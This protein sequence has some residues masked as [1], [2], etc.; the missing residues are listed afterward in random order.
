MTRKD[1]MKRTTRVIVYFLDLQPLNLKEIFGPGI[2]I[3]TTIH[4]GLRKD[5]WTFGTVVT[6]EN[7]NCIDGFLKPVSLSTWI[8]LIIC[9]VGVILIVKQQN[10][11]LR[12]KF[13]R[14][15]TDL[16]FLLLGQCPT[17]LKFV[18]NFKLMVIPLWYFM[19]LILCNSYQGKLF[20]LLSSVMIPD[21]PK[22]IKEFEK[23]RNVPI[24]TTTTGV[25]MKDFVKYNFFSLPHHLSTILESDSIQLRDRSTYMQLIES[26]KT[27]GDKNK[28]VSP[29][30]DVAQMFSAMQDAASNAR[31]IPESNL[32]YW[33]VNENVLALG[34]IIQ[35]FTHQFFIKGPKLDL[36][37]VPIMWITRRNFFH[38]LV[39]PFFGGSMIQGY[40]MFGNVTLKSGEC[41]F[42]YL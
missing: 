17:A 27:F 18:I 35:L 37:Y 31:E 24:Y 41:T 20:H 22:S 21:A 25:G 33:D 10:A 9:L 36:L 28:P 19:S 32:I 4:Y 3:C 6:P 16:A 30:K 26:I 14:R 42:T 38:R 13:Y 23:F 12:V 7:R 34:K 29:F 8:F 1:Y 39:I 2:D 15:P 5:E 11:V 40:M